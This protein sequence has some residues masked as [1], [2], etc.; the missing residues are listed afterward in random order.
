M[1]VFG[2]VVEMSYED[3]KKIFDTNVFGAL[4]VAQAFTPLMVKQGSGKIVN[5]GSISG[6]VA[7]PFAGGYCASKSA[8][9]AF[10]DAMRLEL[11]PFGIDVVVVTPG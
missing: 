1:S 4:L 9:H 6:I 11:K 3:M 7:T 2:P 5:V 10:S 8:I